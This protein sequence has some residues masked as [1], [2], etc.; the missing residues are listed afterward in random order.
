M[1]LTDWLS[2]VVLSVG[3]T[4]VISTSAI[5]EMVRAPV[6]L[7]AAWLKHRTASAPALLPRLTG[8]VIYDL[9]VAG[10]ACP[11]CVG[12]WV[13]FAVAVLGWYPRAGGVYVLEAALLSML[14]SYLVIRTVPVEYGAFDTDE[15]DESR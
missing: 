4:Y 3:I 15:E 1:A 11:A 6:F 2:F 10:I 13:G 14:L 7:G 8:P 9:V 12:F 5:G